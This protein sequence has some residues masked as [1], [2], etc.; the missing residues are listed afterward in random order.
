MA[1]IVTNQSRETIFNN[2]IFIGEPEYGVNNIDEG[3]L[4]SNG[5]F[6]NQPGTPNKSVLQGTDL[7]MTT[8]GSGH[9]QSSGFRVAD[10][11]VVTNPVSVWR[12]GMVFQERLEVPLFGEVKPQ[13][14]FRL[15]LGREFIVYWILH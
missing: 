9:A 11:W 3:T 1:Q 10:D 12:F 7:L 4:Y 2:T 13:M 15:Q 8:Y 14:P 5:P 6:Y